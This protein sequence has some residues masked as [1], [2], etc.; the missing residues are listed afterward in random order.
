M[1]KSPARYQLFVATYMIELK[2]NMAEHPMAFSFDESELAGHVARFATTLTT[3]TFE[4]RGKTVHDTCRVLKI[5][6]TVE[7]VQKYLDAED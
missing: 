2:R 5:E 7:S 1:N 4:L 6:P 3:R